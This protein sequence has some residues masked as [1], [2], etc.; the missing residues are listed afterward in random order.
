MKFLKIIIDHPLKILLII[1]LVFAGLEI[2]YQS[3]GPAQY[4]YGLDEIQYLN[5]L[6]TI[7]TDINKSD[8]EWWHNFIEVNSYY[9][10]ADSLIGFIARHFR[11]YVR[12][13]DLRKPHG[14]IP[15]NFNKTENSIRM[16]YRIFLV[17]ENAEKIKE[18]IDGILD[19]E[20]PKVFT[21]L[22]QKCS[23]VSRTKIIFPREILNILWW[24]DF[25]SK[26]VQR[27]YDF[28]YCEN[29]KS[30]LGLKR[31]D[32]SPIDVYMWYLPTN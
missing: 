19:S 7:E 24:P 14:Y 22:Y 30:Y 28:L 20:P 4:G 26:D 15:Y 10:P 6:Q 27:K 29:I 16:R 18:G 17:Y 32:F 31:H 13:K 25:K 23:I 9:N 2:L 12:H 1:V 8:I 3:L 5:K 21:N 11:R